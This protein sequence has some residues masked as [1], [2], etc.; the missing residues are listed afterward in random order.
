MVNAVGSSNQD[1][2]SVAPVSARCSVFSESL[3]C[4]AVL[5]SNRMDKMLTRQPMLTSASTILALSSCARASWRMCF[6]VL[7]S[8]S[9]LRNSR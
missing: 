4:L 6:G 2:T 8:I 7:I 3:T 5:S 1:T 9:R